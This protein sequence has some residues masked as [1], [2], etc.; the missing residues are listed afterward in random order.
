MAQVKKI[1]MKFTSRSRFHQL[2]DCIMKYYELADD[3]KNMIWVFSFDTDDDS[4]NEKDFKIFMDNL[5]VDYKYF[6]DISQNKIHAINRDVNKID[7]WDILLNISDDQMPTLQGYDNYI[8]REMDDNNS[9]SLWFYD[10]HQHRVNTQEIIGKNY[11]RIFNYVY[12]PSYKSLFCDNEC[13]DVGLSLGKL[14]KF[15]ISIIRHYHPSWEVGSVIR[16]DEL[17]RK[18]QA[19]WSE[20]ETNYHNRKAQNFPI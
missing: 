11:Y 15:E 5:N 7:D 12:H 13:T 9:L 20:D 4:F 1:L 19:Y 6:L 10:G 14:K 3:T 16:E 2:K 17:Y 8:R 18:N